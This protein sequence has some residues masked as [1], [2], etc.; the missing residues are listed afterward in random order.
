MSRMAW[1]EVRDLLVG[2]VARQMPRELVARAWPSANSQL[3][4]A[5]EPMLTALSFT[6]IAKEN[7][8]RVRP[9]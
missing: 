6:T 9:R 5:L 8:H 4:A 2:G 1:A 7:R 3:R